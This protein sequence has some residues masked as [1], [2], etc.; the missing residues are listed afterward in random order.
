MQLIVSSV[1]F[2]S[3]IFA[4]KPTGGK[5]GTR[6]G[7]RLSAQSSLPPPQFT[8]I[9]TGQI[10]EATQMNTT[11]PFGIRIHLEAAGG[12]LLNATT[13]EVVGSV[14][15]FAGNGVTADSGLSFPSGMRLLTWR[16]D[17]HFVSVSFIGAG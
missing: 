14:L 4:L 2:R 16:T 10:S 15:S 6:R 3:S 9:F 7:R 11:G 5:H 17:G 1:F 8:A 13:G 12:D